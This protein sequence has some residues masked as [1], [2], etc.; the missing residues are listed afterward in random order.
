MIQENPNIR[1]ALI[2]QRTWG[3]RLTCGAYHPKILLYPAELV[4]KIEEARDLR[5]KIFFPVD[6]S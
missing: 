3:I 5:S 1:I 2:R 6:D 4:Q